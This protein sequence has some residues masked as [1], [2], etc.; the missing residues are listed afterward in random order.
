MELG[1]TGL[2]STG[3]TTLFNAL[4]GESVETGGYSKSQDPH[5]AVVKVPDTRVDTLSAMFEPKKTTH[6]IVQYADV[7]GLPI[8]QTDSRSQ[9]LSALRTVDALI[10]VVRA[11][12][13]ETMPLPE[14]GIDPERDIEVF[15][16]ELILADLEL[17]ERR[18]D[19]LRREVQAGRR[20][21]EAE[22][23]VLKRCH[24][25]LSAEKPLRALDFQREEERL[26]RGYQF[27]T[28]KPMIIVV[29]IGE[30][31]TSEEAAIAAKL[32]QYAEAADTSLAVLCAELEMEIAQLDEADQVPFLEEL[33][34]T[35]PALFR[36]IRES[37]AL[38]DVISF[39]TVGKDEVRAW[40]VKRGSTAPDAAGAIHSDLQ[41]GFIRAEVVTYDDLIETG[42]L[43]AARDT[44]KLRVEGKSYVVQDGDILNIRFN[45]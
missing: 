1:I 18:I 32:S 24:E 33:G 19:R 42:S 23:N 16:L 25:A 8:G 10:H 27:L 14:G 4:T 40:T 29:N 45:L 43:A 38:L 12:E 30:G 13:S 35:E 31:Q 36:L 21:G 11:F 5:L 3:K 20:E 17:I 22:L 37:Y 39:F 26:I 6:A 28:L 44:G 15:D 7:A 2:P 34:V 41:R 9:F